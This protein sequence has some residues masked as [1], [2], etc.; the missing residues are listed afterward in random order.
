MGPGFAVC[1]FNK[2]VSTSDVT[3]QL[4][5]L[6]TGNLVGEIVLDT[7]DLMVILREISNEVSRTVDALQEVIGRHRRTTDN[8]ETLREMAAR[9]PI[10]GGLMLQL[11]QILAEVD[12][13][14]REDT[15]WGPPK[16]S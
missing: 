13:I 6:A 1:K 2:E 12:R 16:K 14:G 7:N 4:V 11:E 10:P 8:I 9:R 3:L 5:E 15:V